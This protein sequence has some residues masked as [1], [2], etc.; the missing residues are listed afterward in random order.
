MYRFTHRSYRT[1]EQA[2]YAA[3]PEQEKALCKANADGTWKHQ[4]SQGLEV[5]DSGA[6]LI[7]LVEN[8]TEF[9][10]VMVGYGPGGKEKRIE[11]PQTVADYIVGRKLRANQEMQ[12]AYADGGF[13]VDAVVTRIL[14]KADFGDYVTDE[15]TLNLGTASA[16]DAANPKGRR[17]HMRALA[18]SWLEKHGPEAR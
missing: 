9:V 10:D 7:G 16:A 15:G 4:M 2:V 13:N 17:K 18:K 12:A 8:D 1:I 5:P 6:A 14:A 3:L 11:V